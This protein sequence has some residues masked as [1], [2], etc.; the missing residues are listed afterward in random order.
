MQAQRELRFKT[1]DAINADYSQ[2]IQKDLDEALV[3][4]REKEDIIRLLRLENIELCRLAGV[5][6]AN[7]EGFIDYICSFYNKS[8]NQLGVHEKKMLSYFLHEYFQWTFTAIGKF[9]GYKDHTTASKHHQDIKEN[10]HLDKPVYKNLLLHRAWLRKS[11]YYRDE[12]R[13]NRRIG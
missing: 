13:D 11:N 6:M 5:R 2:D 12:N 1:R 4:L 9:L 10:M 7:E 8:L 3:K